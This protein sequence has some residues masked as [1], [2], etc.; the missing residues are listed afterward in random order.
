MRSALH[1]AEETWFDTIAARCGSAASARILVL[2]VEDADPAGD[3]EDEDPDSVLALI[4]TVPGNVSLESMLTEI[5]K[6]T[7][8]RAIGLSP[9]LFADVVPK[10]M[11]GWRAR[12][13]RTES[14]ADPIEVA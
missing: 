7:A 11:T 8:I 13:R 2:I 1:N 10:V 6:L 5:R 12:A 14:R 3:G 4:K 9:G